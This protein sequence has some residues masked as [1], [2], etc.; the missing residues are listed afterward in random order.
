MREAVITCTQTTHVIGRCMF[1]GKM[2]APSHCCAGGVYCKA[3]C[4]VCHPPKRVD[5]SGIHGTVEPAEE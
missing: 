5:F 1:C 3:H 2:A 4:P